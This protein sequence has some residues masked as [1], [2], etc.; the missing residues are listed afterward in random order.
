MKLEKTAGR[1]WCALTVISVAATG[2]SSCGRPHGPPGGAAAQSAPRGAARAVRVA[3][4]ESRSLEGGLTASGNLVSREEAAVNSDISGYRVARVN[5]EQGA[6]VKAGQPLVE[7]DDTLLRAQIEEAAAQ[8]E[9]AD[10]QARNVQGLDNQGVLSAE[11]IQTRRIT[12]RMQD[13]ALQ[14]LKTR[15]AHM[16]IRAPVSGFILERNV[17]P[18]DIAT[19]ASAT[20]MFRMVRDGLVELNAEVNEA[21]FGGIHLG[22]PVKVTLP[23]SAVVDGKVRLIDPQVDATTKL[24]H[25]RI[26]LPVR[27]DL[28]PGGFA[29]ATF[30]G[31]SVA[32]RAVPEIAIRYDADGAS[33][34]VVGADDRVTQVPVK[35][36]RR[37][38]GYVELVEGPSVG[39]RVLLGAASFV[40]SG[41][42]VKP[43]NDP[44]APAPASA[45]GR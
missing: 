28:R 17:R 21:D 44:S 43:V 30:E 27:Q 1:V 24:G 15:E 45:Q 16:T 19:A 38:G 6:W 42:K 11:Q 37:S 12:A 41:D 18:G 22:D 35:T 9:Q 26:Q 25:V 5:F 8:A 3:L 40:L 7:L 14:D 31:A 20:P 13:A 2:L 32:Q 33:V 4:V 39:S 23:D 34:M 29:R 36:G 10:F